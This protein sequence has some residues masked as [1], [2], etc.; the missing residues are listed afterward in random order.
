MV[1][2]KKTSKKR[3]EKVPHWLNYSNFHF[4]AEGDEG[5]QDTVSEED[6]ENASVEDY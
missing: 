5:E 3:T 1:V 4:G 6:D 2:L